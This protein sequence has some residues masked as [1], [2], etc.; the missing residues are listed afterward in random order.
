MVS[1]MYPTTFTTIN[2]LKV[3]TLYLLSTNYTIS[4]SPPSLSSFIIPPF[5]KTKFTKTI[6]N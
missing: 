2:F 6:L 4:S 3:K 5:Q 1:T